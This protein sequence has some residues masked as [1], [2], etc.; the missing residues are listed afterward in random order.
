LKLRLPAHA[1]LSRFLAVEVLNDACQPRARMTN[2]DADADVGPEFLCHS[3]IDIEDVPSYLDRFPTET[4][5]STR[6]FTL[7]QGG[8]DINLPEGF[9]VPMM[10]NAEL[11]FVAQAL[12][13]N[14]KDANFDV[15]QVVEIDFIRNSDLPKPL[16]PLVQVSAVG[17]AVVNG[18]TGLYGVSKEEMAEKHANGTSCMVG[19]P[20][21]TGMGAK[22]NEM[23]DEHSQEFTMFWKM[24]PG[25]SVNH[26]RVTEMIRLRY[27]TNLHYIAVHMHPFAETIELRDVTT[28]ETVYKSHATNEKKKIGLANLEYFGSEEGL[29][30]YADHEYEII[31]TYN[32]TSGEMQDAMAS[33]FLYIHADD[34]YDFYFKQKK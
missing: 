14:I 20:E 30:L 13:H 22:V 32:N 5:L 7:T 27:D 6:I 34:M 9:G 12:N 28:G 33:M 24:P 31:D 10:S 3:N 23:V 1:T 17:L 15:R 4:Y 26:T 16:T 19:V 11:R 25:R 29:P 8:L 2:G 18:T 21:D